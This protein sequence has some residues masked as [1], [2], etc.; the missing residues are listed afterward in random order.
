M[1]NFD[2][3][4]INATACDFDTNWPNLFITQSHVSSQRC[5][6]TSGVT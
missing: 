3:H 6:L 2:F 1:F 5:S 4:A